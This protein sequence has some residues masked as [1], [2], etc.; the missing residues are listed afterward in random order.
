MMIND[1]H[2]LL[3]RIDERVSTLIDS[4]NKVEEW[5]AKQDNRICQLEACQNQTNGRDTAVAVIVSFTTAIVTL[6]ISL[7]TG[8]VK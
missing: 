7:Y 3:A 1:D 5:M 4:Q 6:A 2:T 8:L